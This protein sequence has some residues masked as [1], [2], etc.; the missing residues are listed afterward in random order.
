[1][2]GERYDSF[3][4]VA[5]LICISIIKSHHYY[6]HFTTKFAHIQI[7]GFVGYGEVLNGME[8]WFRQF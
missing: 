8:A 7:S 4:I 3:H 6:M 1:M 5:S 2:V